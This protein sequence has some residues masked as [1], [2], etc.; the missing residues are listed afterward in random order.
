MVEF[1]PKKERGER[2]GYQVYLYEWPENQECLECKH[3]AS[4]TNDDWADI[5]VYSICNLNHNRTKEDKCSCFTLKPS[6][7][8]PDPFQKKED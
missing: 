8:R 3:S 4:I 5:T 2:M 1:I 6:H 7:F